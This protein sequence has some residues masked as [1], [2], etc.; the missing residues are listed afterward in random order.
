MIGQSKP[1]IQVIDPADMDRDD[2]CIYYYGKDT[3]PEIGFGA[4]QAMAGAASFRYIKDAVSWC[5]LGFLD[6]IA[7][8]PIHKVSI[9]QAEIPFIGHTEMLAELTGSK[10]PMTMFQVNNLKIF[11][12]SRHL[13]LIQACRWIN[14]TRVLEGI[15]QSLSGLK[16]LGI[17]DPKLAVAALNPHGGD[18]GLFGDEEV[19]HI[20]PAVK[21]A[22]DKGWRVDGPLPADSVFHLAALGRYD[23]VLSLYHDQGHIATKMMDFHATI[24]VTLGLPFIRTSVDHGTGMDIAGKGIAC[25][26]S[27][28][29]AI[30]AA[31]AYAF[32]GKGDA[33]RS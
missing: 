12:L 16:S 1:L 4:V 32:M 10:N 18:G 22:I 2:D 13:S 14:K 6:G 8:A 15:A 7:T 23:A 29:H 9:Q 21:L 27:M 31:I 25:A 3:A 19:L 17:E 30:E 11:F 24:S 20:Q 28:E 5:Q 26:K 33:C